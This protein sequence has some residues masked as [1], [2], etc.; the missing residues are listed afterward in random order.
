M[1]GRGQCQAGSRSSAVYVL[2]SVITL[3]RSVG[4]LCKLMPK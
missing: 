3:I 1:F 4:A 2:S